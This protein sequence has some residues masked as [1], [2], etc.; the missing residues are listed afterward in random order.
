MTEALRR[1]RRL[2]GKE[3]GIVCE[4]AVGALA[5][6]LGVRLLGLRICRA[7]VEPKATKNPRTSIAETLPLA[8]RIARLE[9]ATVARLPVHTSCLEQSLVLCWMLKRR[10]MKPHLR[11]GGRKQEGRFEAHA[12][13]ELDGAALDC[14]GTEYLHF[15]PFGEWDASLGTQTN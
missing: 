1:F 10:G 6:W 8:G 13:V 11:V 4:A 3:R 12:W 5:A 14:G 7:A 2:G 15:V 9:A